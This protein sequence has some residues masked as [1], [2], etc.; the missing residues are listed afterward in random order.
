VIEGFCFFGVEDNEIVN[1][2]YL[3]EVPLY[4][5]INIKCLYFSQLNL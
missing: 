1:W 4:H 2:A 3:E 5:F